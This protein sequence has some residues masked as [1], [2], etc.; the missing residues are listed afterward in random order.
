M[1]TIW[2]ILAAFAAG[3]AAGGAGL[4]LFC[5]KAH[6]A[7]A[8]AVRA[9]ERDRRQA[10][11]DAIPALIAC[12]DRDGRHVFLNANQ[13][14]QFGTT[15][16]EAVGRTLADLLGH[17]AARDA[18]ALDGRVLETGLSIG[19]A[20]E[21]WRA[22]AGAE[23]R[24]LCT[25]VPVRERDGAVNHVITVAFDVTEQRAIEE[26]LLRS[27]DEAEQ[28]NRAKAMFLANM[29]HELRTPLNAVIGFGEVIATAMFG[30]VGNT[31]YQEYA[32]DIVASGRYLLAIIT[33]I[34]DLSK[35]EAGRVEIVDET[36]DLNAVFESCQRLG[37]SRADRA[38]VKLVFEAQPDLPMLRGDQRAITQVLV[39]LIANSVKFTP[40][41]GTVR[42]EANLLANED[43]RIVVSDTGI[44]MAKQDIGLAMRSFEQLD[45]GWTKKYEGTGL[46][47]PIAKGL[48][49]SH[50]GKF[51]VAS[52]ANVGTTVT[53]TLP[54][55]RVLSDTLILQA[56]QAGD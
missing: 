10:V 48:I 3:L 31:K 43:L 20:E 18:V 53:I 40:S 34:L 26:R 28:A 5:G 55:E 44:G 30:P 11:I 14:A 27:V 13:A 33:D 42:V 8:A 47:L 24:W 12:R 32:R 25:R 56:A 52:Q 49:E 22:G 46:G 54:A 21:K 6:R 9:A 41:G 2:H 29:S 23:R 15:P 16:A 1:A 50:G 4:F 37:A 36:I 45:R 19:P 39:N 38:G 17:D 7:Q 51:E 35:I